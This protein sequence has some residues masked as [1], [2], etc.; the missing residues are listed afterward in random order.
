VDVAD[1]VGVGV[2]VGVGV[3]E[4][5]DGGEEAAAKVAVAV[6]VTARFD[7]DVTWT[8]TVPIPAVA[9]ETWRAIEPLENAARLKVEMTGV[10][11]PSGPIS[12]PVTG[13]VL[14]S[15]VTV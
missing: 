10:G 4:T 6:A 3:G 14:P 15:T 12:V 1:G 9:I 7:N 5:D 13:P 11:E 8:V 2:A